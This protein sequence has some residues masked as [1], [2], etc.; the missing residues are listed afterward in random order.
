MKS[1]AKI[2]I[3]GALLIGLCG[4]LT[5]IASAANG[6]DICSGDGAGSVYCENR[7]DG[8]QKVNGIIGNVVNVLLMA[9]GVISIV[10]II[11]GGILFGLSS[12]DAQKTA[13]ARNTVLYAVIG[14]AVSVFAAAIVNFV[15]N[16]F[17]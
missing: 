1:I 3:T 8:E 15:F 10:M 11:V 17:Q 9:V 13:R 4:I 12:G 5:P 6:I 16:R 2:L 14:L 7:S